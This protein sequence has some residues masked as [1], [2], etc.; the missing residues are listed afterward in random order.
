MAKGKGG[1]PSKLSQKEINELVEKFERYIEETEIPIVADFAA[2]NGL[3]KQ[4]LYDRPE[5]SDLIKRALSKKEAALEKGA[6][7]GT[8][9]APMAIFSLKQ[10]GWRDK[11]EIEHSGETKHV[12]THDLSTLGPDELAKLEE[13]LEKT[14]KMKT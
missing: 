5:F 6:L 10:L 8:L 2:Q 12:V 13:M 3:H 14:G 9:N 11:H 7:T 1:R 4:Y